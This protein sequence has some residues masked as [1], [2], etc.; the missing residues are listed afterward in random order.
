MRI[1]IDYETRS[2]IDLKKVGSYVYSMHPSTDIMCVG[3]SGGGQWRM[4]EDPPY[5]LFEKLEQ[6][7]IVEA[8][9]AEFEILIHKNISHKR[10]GWPEIPFEKWRCIAAKAAAS[11]LPRALGQAGHALG[12]H[13]VK[14]EAE[15]KRA[16]MKMSKPNSKGVFVETD[17]LWE[18]MLNYNSTDILAEEALSESTSDLSEYELEVWRMATRMNLRGLPVDV[19]GIEKAIKL[20]DE[21]SARLTKRF[22]EI[23]GI[24]RATQRAQFIVWLKG[25]GVETDTTDAQ[26]LEKLLKIG[27]PSNVAEAIRIVRELGRSSVSKYEA[28]QQRASGGRIRGSFLYCGAEATGRWSG[29]GIQP[30]NFP[31][32]SP[33]KGQDLTWEAIHTCDVDGL[34]LFAEPFAALSGALR[35][36]ICAPDGREFICGDFAQV[37][38]RITFWHSGEEAGLDLFRAKEDVYCHTASDIF[39]RKITK[40]DKDERFLGK[41]ATL[42]LG[43]GAGFVKFLV[44]CRN[45]G[46]PKFTREQVYQFVPAGQREA[47]YQWV[48]TEGWNH[49]LRLIPDA[50]KEDA[51]ELVLTKYI[52]DRYR[53][54]YKN[55]VVKLWYKLEECAKQAVLN[56]GKVYKPNE[57]LAYCVVGKF[58]KLRLPSGRCLHYPYPQV[59]MPRVVLGRTISD[60]VTYMRRNMQNQW[61]REGT[62]GG[63]LLENAVQATS[64][65][66]TADA[67]LRVERTPPY[68]DL[69]LTC[70]D[71]IMSEVDC[72]KGDVVEFTHVMEQVPTWAK[73]LPIE[74]ESWRA[75]RYHK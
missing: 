42:A 13:I 32:E 14:D 64:R 33:I 43:F 28:M 29:K 73:G 30:Q 61:V 49:V 21:Y 2:Q 63:K 55:T 54:H 57:R 35:G 65:D 31:R 16:L 75:K 70:H 6:A 72:G 52:V 74:V 17:E 4:G 56:P 5:G 7:E 9:N 8:H 39:N 34:S 46:A 18:T 66:I 40:A 62:Y 27:I 15:G 50:V 25:H 12:L 58:L 11:S 23:T 1:T 36:A 26:T 24:E 48:L 37:E 20:A 41:Q 71:E 10:Y 47:I 67:M 53:S 44:H 60:Q 51:L 69:V 22:Q 68:Q 59:S 19:P 3:W 38:A 45:L